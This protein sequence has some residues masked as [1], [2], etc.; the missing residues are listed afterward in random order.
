MKAQVLIGYDLIEVSVRRKTPH[1]QLVDKKF[2]PFSAKSFS[3]DVRQLILRI[4]KHKAIALLLSQ[5]IGILLNPNAMSVSCVSSKGLEHNKPDKA[6][7]QF[8]TGIV[9]HLQIAVS[10]KGRIL[11]IPKDPDVR[12]LLDTEDPFYCIW[13][14]SVGRADTG[15]HAYSKLWNEAKISDQS[16]WSLF[17]PIKSFLKIVYVVRSTYERWTTALSLRRNKFQTSKSSK[18]MK[19]LLHASIQ[20]AE[21]M[22]LCSSCSTDVRKGTNS[23][24]IRLV[25]VVVVVW[26]LVCREHRLYSQVGDPSSIF[27]CVQ[28]LG[29]RDAQ[30]Y[31]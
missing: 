28:K 13:C 24:R 27:Y 9:Q 26:K 18:F 31:E 25:H 5:Y 6:I 29:D 15:T 12:F 1:S 8:H 20:H 23:S 4:D 19:F 30:L 14:F 7:F 11:R 17:Q 22:L 21:L 10:A 2:N 3:E 16:T